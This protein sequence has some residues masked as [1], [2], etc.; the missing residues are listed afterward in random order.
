[1]SKEES[2]PSPLIPNDSSPP[3]IIP[4][5]SPQSNTKTNYTK[6]ILGLLIGQLLS[7]LSVLNGLC[8]QYLETK[9][10]FLIPLLLTT[11]YYF[12]LFITWI[13]TTREIH[14]P[15]LIYIILTIIDSQANFINVYTFSLIQFEYPFI[16]NFSSS[17]WT[18]LLTIVFIKK[19]KYKIIHYISILIS[20]IGILLAMLGTLHSLSDISAMFTNIKGLLLC[21][22][23]SILYAVSVILQE[24]Y[25]DENENIYH[26]FPWFGIIGTVITFC[27]SFVFGELNKMID[28]T[29]YDLYTIIAFIGFGIILV[30]FTSISPFFI[31][32][33]SALMFNIGLA[34][35]VFWSYIGNLIMN[36]EGDK[37]VFYFIGFVIIVSG[38]VL[39]YYR[40]V[41][42][43]K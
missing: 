3:Q 21:L 24:M 19:Y 26:Y 43:R 20:F 10:N 9:R 11:S 31:K 5:I 2:D 33:F 16:I 4:D 35:T 1:M 18:F 38:L 28:Y 40:E 23:T 13:I 15:K 34:S 17:I 14:R 37:N 7:I 39:F 29:N 32:K 30:T 27:E 8:S 41:E 36:N 42:I 12:L 25:L 22:F 6:I